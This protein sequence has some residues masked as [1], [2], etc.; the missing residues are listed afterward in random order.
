MLSEIEENQEEGFFKPLI[1]NFWSVAW[2]LVD[3]VTDVDGPDP[4]NNAVGSDPLEQTAEDA[5]LDVLLGDAAGD[6]SSDATERED[7]KNEEDEAHGFVELD[8]GGF[9]GKRPLVKA[10]DHIF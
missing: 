5:L 2:I 3:A 10:I 9:L 1:M 4:T 7:G 6:H 8:G